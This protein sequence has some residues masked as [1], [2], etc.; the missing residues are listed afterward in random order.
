MLHTCFPS[1]SLKYGYMLGKGCIC[2]QPPK[3]TLDVETL[4]S[5]LVGNISNMLSQVV[6][7]A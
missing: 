2:N 5:F 7:R 6:A 3:K 1:M 4:I